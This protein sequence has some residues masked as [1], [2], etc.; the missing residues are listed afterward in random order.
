VLPEWG[1][2]DVEHGLQRIAAPVGSLQERREA[3]AGPEELGAEEF[4]PDRGGGPCAEE[5]QL[6]TE[7][8]Q[9]EPPDSHPHQE[10]AEPLQ[11]RVVAG[12]EDVRG[13][14]PRLEEVLE[15][16]IRAERRRVHGGGHDRAQQVGRDG[17]QQ[18]PARRPGRE[19]PEPE[20]GE[21]QGHQEQHAVVEEDDGDVRLDAAEDEPDQ[22]DDQ[23]AD[24]DAAAVGGQRPVPVRGVPARQQREADAGDD[25]EQARRAAGEDQG[26]PGGLGGARGVERED[27]RAH[28]PEERHA[29][30]RVDPGQPP[31]G[32]GVHPVIVPQAALP[33]LW[34]LPRRSHRVLPDRVTFYPWLKPPRALS[35]SA[36]S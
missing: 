14:R 28:H 25:G 29:T 35:R 3:A 12:Q 32:L 20:P 15:D 22:G 10:E 6:H 21:R 30:G 31:G 33:L 19:R 24:G 2:P 23:R 16:R 1:A 27:V 5:R 34:N 18:Q 9:V 7:V 13:E 36:R 8:R 4:G 17:S 26:R 11:H